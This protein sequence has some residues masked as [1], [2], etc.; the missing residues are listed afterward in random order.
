[1]ANK[2]TI[3]GVKVWGGLEARYIQEVRGSFGAQVEAAFPEPVDEGVA[4]AEMDRLY[5]EIVLPS[6]TRQ[7]LALAK[8]DPIFGNS[9]RIERARLKTRLEHEV[10]HQEVKRKKRQGSS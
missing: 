7:V 2:A 9:M 1:M 3:V 4:S 6:L 8:Q 10:R 5:N